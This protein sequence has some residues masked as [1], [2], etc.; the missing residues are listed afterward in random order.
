MA[1]ADP[2]VIALPKADEA[3]EASEKPELAIA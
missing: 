1:A 2:S 3:V